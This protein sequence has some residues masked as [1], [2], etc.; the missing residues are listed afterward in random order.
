MGAVNGYGINGETVGAGSP[1]SI[2]NSGQISVSSTRTAIGIFGGGG[3]AVS[4]VSGLGGALRFRGRHPQT[5]LPTSSA[6]RSAPDL[7][8]ATPT[9]R[10]C[11]SPASFK[12]PVRIS[13]GG[14][15]GRPPSNG[16]KTTLYPLRG[17]RFHEPCW[18]M[19]A[20]PK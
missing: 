10:P 13:S 6:T 18:P 11:A 5:V 9:G 20:P 3:S 8:T 2:V 12:N 7:S 15:E 14:P 17:V 1:G 16:M 19:K 4:I